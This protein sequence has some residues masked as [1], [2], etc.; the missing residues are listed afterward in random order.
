[1]VG[2]IIVD[3]VKVDAGKWWVNCVEN[4]VRRTPDQCAI[5]LDPLGR[6]VDVGDTVWWQGRS[7]FWTPAD[8][9]LIDVKLPRIGCSGVSHP[10]A[11]RCSACGCTLA[12]C[13]KHGVCRG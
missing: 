13:Q 6:P 4:F 12:F 1:M 10:D 9:S 3:I 2:G 7:A 11:P 5:Y 8:R